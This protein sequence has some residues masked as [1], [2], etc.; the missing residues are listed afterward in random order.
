MF[1][2][3]GPAFSGTTLLALLLNQD[4]I[5]FLDE[6]DFH[7]PEQS[8]RGLPYL[9]ELFPD[10]GLPADPGCELDWEE[11]TDLIEGCAEAIR[12]VELG[13]KTCNA[14]F[15]GYGDVYR[16]RGYPVVSIFRDI[17]DALSRP[18]PPWQSEEKLNGEYRMVWEQRDSFDLWFRYEELV[19]APDAVLARIG[20]LLGRPLEVPGRWGDDR[21]NAH[22]L[23]LDRHELLRAGTISSS[24]V[25]IW[26][27]AGTTLSPESHETARLMGYE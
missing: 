26:R 20:A 24:R 23:K 13:V 9:H 1:L 3:G 19:V 11:A 17:R 7:D 25:G 4:G 5:V 21:V 14:Y 22:M 27:D 16:R 10:A 12:P 15:L 18:L 6:P 2:I 8:H